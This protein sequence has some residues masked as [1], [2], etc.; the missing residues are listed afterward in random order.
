M[1]KSKNGVLAVSFKT[2]GQSVL[3]WYI[4]VKS[5]LKLVNNFI[6]THLFI[7]ENNSNDHRRLEQSF[8][9]ATISPLIHLSF[10]RKLID[11]YF[12][13]QLIVFSTFQV[14]TF[15]ICWFQP[16]KYKDLLHFFVILDSK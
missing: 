12:D 8:S 9:V 15:N 3:M 13:N 14:K 4:S 10:E 7:E 1:I 11:H 2:I 6:P 5:I 16:L